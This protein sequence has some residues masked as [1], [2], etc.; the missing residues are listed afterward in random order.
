MSCSKPLPHLSHYLSP[1][2]R[3]SL[4]N[5]KFPSFGCTAPFTEHSICFPSSPT[6]L[7]DI[8]EYLCRVVCFLAALVFFATYSFHIRIVCIRHV[9]NSFLMLVGHVGS[10]SCVRSIAVLVEPHVHFVACVITCVIHVSVVIASCLGPEPRG[11]VDR[12]PVCSGSC[13]A[14]AIFSCCS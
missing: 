12:A 9:S 3:N 10:R 7:L 8:Y 13:V 11:R 14:F 5:L 2:V 1:P 4:S 6:L